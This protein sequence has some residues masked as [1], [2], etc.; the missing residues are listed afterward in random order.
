MKSNKYNIDWQIARIKAKRAKSFSEKTDIV[1][2]YISNNKTVEAL[3]RAKNWSN[4]FLGK[5]KD[6]QEIKDF[7]VFLSNLHYTVEETDVTN[8]F[9]NADKKIM[10]ALLKDLLQRN[11]KWLKKGYRHKDQNIFIMDLF[12]AFEWKEINNLMWC[13]YIKELNNSFNIENT[14]KFMF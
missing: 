2:E 12:A 14:H 13:T 8:D 7:K 6:Y 1:R 10:K 11:S 4:S 5:Y 9:I 3:D